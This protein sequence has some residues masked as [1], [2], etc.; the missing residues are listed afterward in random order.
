MALSKNMRGFYAKAT[1]ILLAEHPEHDA[2][3]HVGLLTVISG[4]RDLALFLD[5]TQ[6]NQLRLCRAARTHGLKALITN[7]PTSE[8][9]WES[10][11]PSEIVGLFRQRDDVQGL[12]LCSTAR[13][14][15]AINHSIDQ[16]AAA[17]ALAYPPCCIKADQQAKS[18]FEHAVIAGYIRHFGNNPEEI[19]LALREDRKVPLDWEPDRRLP[20]TAAKFPFVQHIACEECLKSDSSATGRLNSRFETVVKDEHPTLHAYL[21]A[22]ARRFQ[23]NADI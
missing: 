21:L 20:R 6:D 22:T 2:L 4:L 13:A 11:H 7:A 12:W 16:L 18:D 8:W 3:E 23:N 17:E 19:A 15:R 9:T 5:M 14:E 10:P 1:H